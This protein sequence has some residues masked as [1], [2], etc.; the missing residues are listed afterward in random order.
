[1]VI[2]LSVLD[3]RYYFKPPQKIIF[4]DR[5]D[6]EIGQASKA[7]QY[8]DLWWDLSLVWDSF[9]SPPE[10]YLW[11]TINVVL[12]LLLHWSL[13]LFLVESSLYYIPED[14]RRVSDRESLPKLVSRAIPNNIDKVLYSRKRSA[15]IYWANIVTEYDDGGSGLNSGIPRDLHVI[16]EYTNFEYLTRLHFNNNLR[17]IMFCSKNS[18]TAIH[19]KL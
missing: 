14:L 10:N 19:L 1:M 7:W 16:E 9:S 6:M 12:L 3:L 4:N 5:I 13:V 2:Y 8:D 18:I 17:S 11:F 15:R